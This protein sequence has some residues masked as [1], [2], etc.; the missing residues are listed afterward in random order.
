MQKFI[1]PVFLCCVC[2]ISPGKAFSY[3][4]IIA[5]KYIANS[6]ALS[7]IPLGTPLL[8][9]TSPPSFPHNSGLSCVPMCPC[10]SAPMYI[11]GI[12]FSYSIVHRIL[13]PIQPKRLGGS[14]STSW[15]VFLF[16]T[17]FSICGNTPSVDLFGLYADFLRQSGGL[18]SALICPRR[19][20][21]KFRRSCLDELRVDSYPD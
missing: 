2:F 11:H 17:P 9:F 5:S 6:C 10:C 4:C 15:L 19:R 13:L 7:G 12:C 18:R 20:I 16:F 8:L 14:I 1:S 3:S 21:P